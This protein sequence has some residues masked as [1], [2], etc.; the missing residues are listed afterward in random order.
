[1]INP[2][3]PGHVS[4]WV[5]PGTENDMCLLESGGIPPGMNVA[6]TAAMAQLRF[7]GVF[8]NGKGV[9]AVSGENAFLFFQPKLHINAN[10]K[11]AIG[12]SVAA[13]SYIPGTP[14]QLAVNAST[15]QDTLVTIVG[16]IRFPQDKW[17]LAGAGIELQGGG[18]QFDET[19]VFLMPGTKYR[20]RI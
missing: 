14:G 18:L 8:A 4:W 1:M 9:W 2:E 20:K 19:G 17:T 16:T 11:L 7:N 12:G 10:A 15:L 3:G 13:L 6:L 5:E